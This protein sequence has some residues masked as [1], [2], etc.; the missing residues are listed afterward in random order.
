[1]APIL[2]AAPSYLSGDMTFGELM[3]IVGA[4]N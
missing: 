2:V 1:V 4:F 3:M